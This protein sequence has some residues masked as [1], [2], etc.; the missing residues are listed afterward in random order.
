[1][2]DIEICPDCLM[3]LNDVHDPCYESDE[4]RDLDNA[5]GQMRFEAAVEAGLHDD[6]DADYDGVSDG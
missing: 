1:M 6:D 2:S 5:I 3:P 4:G